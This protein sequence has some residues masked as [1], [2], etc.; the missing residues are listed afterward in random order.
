MF[1]ARED[2]DHELLTQG[3]VPSHRRLV[4]RK[5][6]YYSTDPSTSSTSIGT[7]SGLNPY[8]GSYYL[9]AMTSQGYPIGTPIFSHRL[10]HRAPHLQVRP[11]I[12]IPLKT[13][14]RLGAASAGTLSSR[15]AA[16]TCWALPGCLLRTA[17]AYT[18]P[19]EDMMYPMHG[20]PATESF[21]I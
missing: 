1:A 11:L 2:E 21:K 14:L 8:A 3:L 15:P 18:Q 9:S 16:S 13:T 4:Y 20:H 19:S 10:E 7:C 5:A 6:S 17:P 12:G